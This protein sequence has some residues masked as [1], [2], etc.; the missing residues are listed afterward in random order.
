LGAAHGEAV[1]RLQVQAP[2]DCSGSANLV[3]HLH[4]AESSLASWPAPGLTMGC[5]EVTPVILVPPGLRQGEAMQRTALSPFRTGSIYVYMR[6]INCFKLIFF[7]LSL[8]LVAL[9]AAL[10]LRTQS[11][12]AARVGPPSWPVPSHVRSPAVMDPNALRS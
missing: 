8:Q 5:R 1:T 7:R 12:A 2:V 6:C 4:V 11:P 10:R 3:A 9:H